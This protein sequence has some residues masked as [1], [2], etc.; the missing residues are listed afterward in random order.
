MEREE[1]EEVPQ[2]QLIVGN[3]GEGDET[4][5]ASQAVRSNL[6]QVQVAEHANVMNQRVE[7][8]SENSEVIFPQ[9]QPASRDNLRMGL[10]TPLRRT[11]GGQI[12]VLKN[13]NF[14]P[15]NL[16]FRIRRR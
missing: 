12:N 4:H 6:H 15:Q 1:E 13:I 11:E 16:D 14:L 7:G 10:P 8:E 9:N 3:H 2:G 5:D